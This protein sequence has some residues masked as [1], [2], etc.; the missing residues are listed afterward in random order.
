M[1]FQSMHQEL[2]G[3]Y[4]MISSGSYGFFGGYLNLLD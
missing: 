4:S 3:P 2:S 1:S